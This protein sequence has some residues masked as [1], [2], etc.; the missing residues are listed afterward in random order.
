MI[1]KSLITFAAVVGSATAAL[2]AESVEFDR[3]KLKDPAYVQE[4]Y[5]EIRAVATKTCKR[6]YR[7]DAFYGRRLRSCIETTVERTVKSIGAREL[8]AYANGPA[9]RNRVAS[10]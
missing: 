5:V 10:R 8:T 6:E 7:G 2:A 4:L 1:R 3:A 9:K